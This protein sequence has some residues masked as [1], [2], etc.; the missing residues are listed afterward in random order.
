MATKIKS[1]K[2]YKVYIV[3]TTTDTEFITTCGKVFAKGEVYK[4]GI[5]SGRV[6]SIYDAEGICV[7]CGA[8]STEAFCRSCDNSITSEGRGGK[9]ASLTSVIR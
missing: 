2:T 1:K 6:R 4:M 9:V 3:A 7:S 5:T 8:K